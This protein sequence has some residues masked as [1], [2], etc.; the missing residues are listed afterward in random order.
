[1]TRSARALALAVPLLMVAVGA[2]DDDP[3][4]PQ[5]PFELTFSGDA[6]F[7]GAHADQSIHVVVEDAAGAVVASGSGT[8]S[9]SEDPAFSFTFQDILEEG[10]AYALKYW[11]DS[12]F[13]EEGTDGVC[14]PPETDHQWEID[15]PAV[16]DDVDIDDVHRPA[17]T[18]SVCEAFTFD[19]DFTGDASFQGAHGG[20]TIHVAVIHE[21][22]GTAVATETGTVSG[23]EDPAFSFSFPGVLTRDAEYHLDY[24][25][26]SNFGG[27][28]VGTC[29]PIENDHQW[30][31]DEIGP[32]TDAVT[33]DD[34]HRPTETEDVCAT[35]EG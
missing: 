19:L 26:D 15:I 17:E 21:G 4:Q 28:T 25:I 34:V 16:S 18:S 24:W 32:V 22:L 12:N 13:S 5:G 14:D 29:D 35:F 2:C 31:I 27:G 7:Q 20:Q 1:M 3:V 10:Q 30:R 6:S 8:V 9:G 33:I 11:I 23:S